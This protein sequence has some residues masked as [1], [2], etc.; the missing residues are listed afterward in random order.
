MSIE[1]NKEVVEVRWRVLGEGKRSLIQI[2]MDSNKTY[3]P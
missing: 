3:S 1:N 2:A